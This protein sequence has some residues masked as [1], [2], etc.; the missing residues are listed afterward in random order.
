MVNRF[1]P[2]RRWLGTLFLVLGAAMLVWGLT[3]LDSRLVGK[4]F[5]IYWTLCFLVTGLA[6]LISLWDAYRL[7]RKLRAEEKALLEAML[8]QVQ[9]EQRTRGSSRREDDRRPATRKEA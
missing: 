9:K 1:F 3:V 4:S 2:P 7:R 8:T 5:I 6:L